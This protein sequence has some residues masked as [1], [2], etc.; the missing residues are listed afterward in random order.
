MNNRSEL[1]NISLGISL[2]SF[3]L[4]SYLLFRDQ[5]NRT[6]HNKFLLTRQFGSYSLIEGQISN[7]NPQE[8]ELESKIEFVGSSS[9]TN[10]A[11]YHA[12]HYKQEIASIGE[13]DNKI[14]ISIPMTSTYKLWSYGP[15]ITSINPKTKLNDFTLVLDPKSIIQFDRESTIFS[16]GN[17]DVQIVK[18]YLL[19][20]T[21]KSA[22]GALNGSIMKI[23]YLGEESFVNN[24]IKSD[25]FGINNFYTGA[26]GTIAIGTCVFALGN[27]LSR[28]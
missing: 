27:I 11:V 21:Y 3:I 12:T 25:H 1:D 10:T 2:G 8:T 23:R 5:K 9:Q 19:N 6:S 24:R 14:S 17:C 4:S 26:V 20:D 22:F 16:N 15:V 7:P 28:L 13:A 18:K